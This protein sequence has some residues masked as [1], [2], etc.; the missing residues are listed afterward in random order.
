MISLNANGLHD[1]DK[2]KGVLQWL[3]SLPS[4]ADVICFQ[5]TH[6]F[7][8]AECNSWFSLSGFS[9][10][11]SPGSAR[12]CGCIVLFRST[13][14]FVHSWCD[15]A[16]RYIQAEFSLHDTCFCVLC[17]NAPNRNP[18]RDL[19]F[20][21]LDALV[22]PGTSTVL[23]GDFNTVFDRSLDCSGSSVDDTS[24]ES[25]LTLTRL[26]SFCCVV[27]ILA[28]SSPG[29]L[30]IYLVQVGWLSFLLY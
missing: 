14:K 9:C 6:C 8:V 7:S 3:T 18:A 2:R 24:R 28:L 30:C 1:L 10:L 27:D 16:G 29:Y 26:F 19:F 15:T 11:V 13:L 17:V 20:D 22:D 4:P 21:Q 23:S 12:S 25:T 5:E